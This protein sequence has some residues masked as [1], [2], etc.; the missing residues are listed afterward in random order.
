VDS[1]P[2][3]LLISQPLAIALTEETD[4]LRWEEEY[5]LRKQIENLPD[6]FTVGTDQGCLKGGLGP[7]LQLNVR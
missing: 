4:E 1:Q 2:N 5:N 3:K 6:I 7:H